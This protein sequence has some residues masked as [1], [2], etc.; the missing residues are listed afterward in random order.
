[1]PMLGLTLRTSGK[2][3]HSM[4]KFE[5]SD[6]VR[7][8]DDATR[9]TTLGRE[10][11]FGLQMP[12]GVGDQ[13][14]FVLSEPGDA[15]PTSPLEERTVT[16]VVAGNDGET[17]EPP[18]LFGDN[19][20]DDDDDM[21]NEPLEPF[22]PIPEDVPD[23]DDPDD[24]I[25]EEHEDVTGDVAEATTTTEVPRL[26]RDP[27]ARLKRKRISRFGVEYPPLPPS[28]V[29]KVAQTALQSSGLSNPRI[30]A[31]TLTALTQASEWFFEQL[32]DDLAAYS[33]HARRKTIEES[34]VVTL[35]RR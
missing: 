33:D 28:F 2:S 11:D 4:F 20:D 1:V 8:D 29:K 24:E 22:D 23:D 18:V 6:K 26:R 32:G 15:A 21:P 19:Y 13:T 34:D 27:K 10:S 35:M 14:T 25:P 5:S 3:R 7:V 30:S 17:E 31:D 9:R 12:E 16:G